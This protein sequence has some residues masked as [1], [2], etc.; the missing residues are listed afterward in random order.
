MLGDLVLVEH[1]RACVVEPEREQARE[2]LAPLSPEG[3]RVLRNCQ[4]VQAHNREEE[5]I[6]LACGLGCDLLDE[7]LPLRERAEVVTDLLRG[8]GETRQSTGEVEGR[9]KVPGMWWIGCY[10]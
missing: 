6:A 2:H 4:G 8:E 9:R 7:L 10:N 1:D 5:R 3:G